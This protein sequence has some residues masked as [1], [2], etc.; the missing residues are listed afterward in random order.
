M[1]NIDIDGLLR[2]E[3]G[4]ESRV[5]RTKIVCTLGPASRSVPMIEKLL[6]AGMNVARF[7]FS[8]GSHEYHQETLDNLR[9]A[10]HNTSILCAVMLD[11]KVALFLSLSL[12]LFP[13]LP[14]LN[15]LSGRNP[16]IAA[17]NLLL[18]SHLQGPEIRTGFLKDGNPIQLQEGQE[19]TI[20]TDYTIKGDPET[21]SMSYKKLPMDV[22]PG[23][24]ILCSDGTISLSVLSCDP[25][26][27]T[28]RCRCQNTA[29][30]GERKNV[31][32]P[33]VVVD[34]PTLTEKDKED[35]LQWGVPNAIDMIA[36][37]FVR[38]GSD[39]VNVRKVL[40]P[41]AKHIKLMSKVE[42]QEG[43]I[44]FD[45]ILRETDAFMVARGD[46]GMEIP[47]EKIFLAQKMMIYKC[48]LVGKP[49]VTATQMLESMIKSPRPTRAEATDVANAVLD[50]TDC[51]MLS[52]ESAAGAYPE[53][54]VKTMRRICIEAESSLDYGAVFKEIMRSTPLPMSPLE[55]LASSAVRTAN[56]ARAK[57]I[58]VLTRGGTTA[59]LVAKY[60][61]AV[62]ILSVVVP[63]LTTD[64]FDWDCSDESP[65]RHSLI[66]RGLIPILA[67]GSAR[68]TDAESTEEILVAALKKAV[69]KGLCKVGD[70]VVALHRIGSASV[71]K[72]CMVK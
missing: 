50:G 51:V 47:V 59:T 64:S 33:G 32:L 11:T 22:K 56:K 24:T 2:G 17:F 62:P 21:I 36:L 55:S 25:E 13:L 45:D 43:V 44:N 29:M 20:T 71:I 7:N 60:R 18:N 72:I 6:R 52:G 26:A 58:V 40:G 65:A 70:A 27:G 63:V 1:A 8:H 31:N 9:I 10:M 5:P 39:L 41:H 69:E 16:N 49:V 48:N 34:L 28:V 68:A 12:C 67:E 53:L 14:I 35:I 3:D 66:Y 42:N 54:A 37:S 57:L 23:N 4:D 61:P 46:L 30:L 15:Q 38:K 19:V